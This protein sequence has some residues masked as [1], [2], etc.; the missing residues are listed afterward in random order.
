MK[1]GTNKMLN[2]LGFKVQGDLG[3]ITCY[4][5]KRDRVVWYPK[6]PPKMPP[7]D[8][9][10]RERDGFRRIGDSWAMLTVEEKAQWKEVATKAHLRISGY[11]L[12][13]FWMLKHDLAAIKTLVRQTKVLLPLP[14]PAW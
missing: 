10:V 6:A 5:S 7:S 8:E 1:T 4:T 12:F 2:L 3:G 11:N 14:S 13:S 9:Q